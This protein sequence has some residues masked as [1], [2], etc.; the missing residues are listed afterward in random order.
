MPSRAIEWHDRHG[1][2][3]ADIHE[4]LDSKAKHD[5]CST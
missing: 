5:G 2:T 1:V 4:R 3:A